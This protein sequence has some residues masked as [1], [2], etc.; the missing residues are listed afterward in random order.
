MRKGRKSTKR[1][2]DWPIYKEK[3]LVKAGFELEPFGIRNE[4]LTQPQETNVL[5]T[6]R[7]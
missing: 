6:Q 4:L 5:S 2:Q 1:G 7:Q 3:K